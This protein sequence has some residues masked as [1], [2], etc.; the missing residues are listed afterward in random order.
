[1]KW[2]DVAARV[3]ALGLSNGEFCR[4]CGL[5]ESAMNKGVRRGSSLSGA[6]KRVAE[7]VLRQAEAEVAA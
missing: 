3:K 5:S 6:V 1:M 4:R 2:N 7:D